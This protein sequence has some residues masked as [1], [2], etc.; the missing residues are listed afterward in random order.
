MLATF[1][2]SYFSF[3]ETKIGTEPEGVCY[4]GNRGENF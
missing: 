1:S 3:D 4:R 2:R